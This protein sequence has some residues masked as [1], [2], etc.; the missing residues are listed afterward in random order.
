MANLMDDIIE[1]AE[2]FIADIQEHFE[3]PLDYSVESLEEVD[4]MLG[5]FGRTELSEDELYN[6]SA[7]VGCYIFEV[8]RR[9]YGGRYFWIEKEQQPVLAAGRPEFS[10]EIKVWEK[11][12][13]RL[14]KGEEDNI[15]FYIAGY[16]EHIEI[17]KTK[18]GYFVTIV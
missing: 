18:P 11:V 2:K 13:G 7:A 5:A 4:K 12:R 17:G 3:S 1:T 16:K 9:N 15:P 14:V 6:T 8:A 10:V